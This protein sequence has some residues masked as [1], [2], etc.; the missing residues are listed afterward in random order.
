MRRARNFRTSR[1]TWS[2]PSFRGRPI[3]TSVHSTAVYQKM[4]ADQQKPGQ[5]ANTQDTTMHYSFDYLQ[6]VHY[7]TNSQQA[8]PVY[9]LTCRKCLVFIVSCESSG[10][11]IFYLID[12]TDN[13]GKGANATCSLFHHYLPDNALGE[14]H[15]ALHFDNCVRQNLNNTMMMYMTW[16][17]MT[18]R[19]TTILVPT[20]LAGHTKFGATW[21]VA[22]SRGSG[23]SPKQAP[24]QR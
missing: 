2:M 18:G 10:R 17:C 15:L 7:P 21:L 3:K 1:S 13:Y 22:L 8:S 14:K 9:F 4:D 12:E 6:Q 20:M 24:W 23:A 16:R 5:A 19:Y 11:S